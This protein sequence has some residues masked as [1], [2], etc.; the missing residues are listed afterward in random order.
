M[1]PK[2]N[3]VIGG[4]TKL[5]GLI[6]SGISY[7]RSP[8][9][10]NR[11][12]AEL[13]ID[14][15]YLPLPMT[16]DAVPGFLRSFWDIGGV[17]LNVTT[18]H[19]GLVA[20]LLR[21]RAKTPLPRS[22]NTLYRDASNP[23]FWSAA[24][25]DGD[26]FVKGLARIGVDGDQIEEMVIVGSGGV[27]AALIERFSRDSSAMKKIMVLRRNNQND[28]V[29]QSAAPKNFPLSFGALSV[30]ALTK[31]LQ[32][33]EATTLFVQATNAPQTGDDLKE[34]VPALRQ[35]EG[36]VCDLIYDKPS[37]LYFAA[38]AQHIKAQ[39]GEAMLI[40]QARLSQKLWWGKAAV[41]EDMAAVLRA[42]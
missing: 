40:E 2:L 16:A 27:V 11:A 36:V 30:D 15:I 24:S 29:L 31:E 13:G 26:G 32:G 35:F 1:S 28:G 10:H 37:A 23:E 25:T 38:L 42:K 22:I 19:K 9:L 6:G 41:Y 34:L 20:D 8:A 14:Q 5:L 21:A 17:G 33:K 4:E 3:S 12:A 39:N 7:T 18:P